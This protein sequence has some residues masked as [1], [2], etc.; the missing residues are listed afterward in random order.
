MN[1][2]ALIH[3]IDNTEECIVIHTSSYNQTHVK[4]ALAIVKQLLNLERLKDMKKS[5][6]LFILL[7]CSMHFD[8]ISMEYPILYFKG[9]WQIETRIV[10]LP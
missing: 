1:V 10:F 7:D 4:F 8:R 9:Q 2:G 5:L 6:S 3:S